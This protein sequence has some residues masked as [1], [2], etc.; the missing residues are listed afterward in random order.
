[1]VKTGKSKNYRKNIVCLE[2]LWTT[3]VE[4]R[5]S[6]QPILELA[7]KKNYIKTILLT[8]NTMEELEF[9]LG[10]VPRR[11]GY[12]IL[13]FAFHGFPGGIIMASSKAKLE[14]IAGFMGK[15]FSNWVVYFGSCA[16]LGI[17]KRRVFNFMEKTNALMAIGYK[18]RV[19]W[20]DSSVIDLLLLDYIQ[21]Y[22]DM[23]KFWDRFRRTYRGLI[24]LTGLDAFHRD[25][26]SP[27]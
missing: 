17:E 7:S 23:R 4:N 25:G 14:T 1:V 15:R 10:I 24:R 11:N 20:M 3:D 16:T 8:C 9:N 2:S 19:N 26:A 27:R 13:Y 12:G 21:E 6:V 5:L 22:K 18:K